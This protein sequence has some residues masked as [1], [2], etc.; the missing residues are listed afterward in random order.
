VCSRS[1]GA[2][3]IRKSKI[4]GRCSAASYPNTKRISITKEYKR[5]LGDELLKDWPYVA[6][7]VGSTTK[8]TYSILKTWR[9]NYLKGDWKRSRPTARR[10]FAKVK[11]TLMKLDGKRLSDC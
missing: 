11:Q 7:W 5:R 8:T 9:K 3:R 2:I 4:K 1:S 6:H 10:L